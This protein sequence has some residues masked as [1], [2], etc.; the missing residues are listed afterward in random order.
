MARIDPGTF[1][2]CDMHSRTL[3]LFFLVYIRELLGI[4]SRGALG[5]YKYLITKKE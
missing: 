3:E 5:C 2:S 4:Y 1:G